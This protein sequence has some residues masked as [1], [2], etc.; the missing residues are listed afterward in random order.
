MLDLSTYLKTNRKKK[1]GR[2]KMYLLT[3]NRSKI[4]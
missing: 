2:K 1:Y 3:K 4:S